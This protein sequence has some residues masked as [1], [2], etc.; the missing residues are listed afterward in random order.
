MAIPLG[1]IRARA[2]S[3]HG[4]KPTVKGLL[5]NQYKRFRGG[6]HKSKKRSGHSLGGARSTTEKLG[7]EDGTSET[8]PGMTAPLVDRQQATSRNLVRS[9]KAEKALS[10]AGSPRVQRDVESQRSLK[11]RGAGGKAAKTENAERGAGTGDKRKGN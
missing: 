9:T 1:D 2:W 6:S 10:G 3:D 5:S 7:Q 8:I 11:E 4:A